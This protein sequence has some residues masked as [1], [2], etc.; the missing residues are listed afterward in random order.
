MFIGVW[1]MLLM[2]V[3]GEVTLR[4]MITPAAALLPRERTQPFAWYQEEVDGT[5]TCEIQRQCC[6][7]SIDAN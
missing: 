5:S 1:I 3:S 6:C 4:S 2:S 7:I